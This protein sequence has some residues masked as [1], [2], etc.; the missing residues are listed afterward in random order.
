VSVDEFEF[1]RHLAKFASQSPQSLNLSDDG[2]ILAGDGQPW[3]LVKD[4]VQAG[5]HA[6]ADDDDG[7][8]IAK[9]IRVNLSDLAA[10]GANPKFIMLGLCLGANSQ[11]SSLEHLAGVIRAEC[12]QFGV[13][14]IGGD[15]VRGQGPTTVSVTAIGQ[16]SGN[17]ILRSGAVAGDDLW[18]TGSIGDGALG[19]RMLQQAEPAPQ[20]ARLNKDDRQALAKR[21]RLPTP[22]ITLGEPLSG[23]ASAMIDV[24]DG[25]AADAAHMA[26][27]S[28]V[29]ITID[30]EQVPVSQAFS[31][32]VDAG[33][34]LA[35][36]WTVLAGGDDYELLFSAPKLAAQDIH[37]IA[38]LT[39]CPITRIGTV[40][41]GSGVV[42]HFDGQAVSLPVHGF[43]HF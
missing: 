25:L 8:I 31:H 27:A 37:R 30:I 13:G 36:K 19:L 22:R 41:A 23:I 18:V 20:F 4:M 21:Y 24:S 35:T 33:V 10:M 42:L 39:Q 5:V 34:D 7:D 15:T 17:P 26:R 16:L 43:T 3:V 14:L 1:I 9:A 12:T 40:N 6:L 2:A 11:L 28:K 32:W 38:R 29:S